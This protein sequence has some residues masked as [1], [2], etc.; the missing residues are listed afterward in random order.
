MSDSQ[1]PQVPANRVVVSTE[2]A[3]S[4]QSDERSTVSLTPTPRGD[5]VSVDIRTVR[6]EKTSVPDLLKQVS[7]NIGRRNS[8]QLEQLVRLLPVKNLDA[9]LS[10]PRPV[11]VPQQLDVRAFIQALVT[12]QNIAAK[13]FV[14]TSVQ[15][16]APTLPSTVLSGSSVLPVTSG[17]VNLEPLTLPPIQ[18]LL[19]APLQESTGQ[20]ISNVLPR[21]FEQTVVAPVVNS[22]AALTFDPTVENKIAFPQAPARPVQIDGRIIQLEPEVVKLKEPGDQGK[23][24][25][26][27][28]LQNIGTDKGQLLSVVQTP[29]A[30]SFRAEVIG[31]TPQNFPVVSFVP[32]SVVSDAGVPVQT[33]NFI[34]QAPTDNLTVGS[35]IHFMPISNNAGVAA[36][37]VETAMQNVI[38]TPF[39]S[40][41]AWP[42]F[43][44]F[45]TV[46]NQTSGKAQA[47]VLTQSMPNPAQPSR[48][49]AAMMFFIAAVRGGDLSAWSGDKAIEIVK[50]VGKSDVVDRL[51]R[52]VGNMQRTSTE[53]IGGQDWRAVA[54]PMTWDNEIHKMMLFFRHDGDDESGDAEQGK[55]TRFIF[56][57]N[58]QRMGA[59][60]LDG[61]TR[62]K[63]LD[64]II[65]SEHQFT[66]LMRTAMRGVYVNAL[67][68]SDLQGELGFQNSFE[69][70][71]KIDME[72]DSSVG[73]SAVN[74][75]L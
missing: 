19:Q 22:N 1:L 27:F 74:S 28:V 35:K 17:F 24:A 41:F 51:S 58:L 6:A 46:L 3:V 50:R 20:N 7:E 11:S 12:P 38:A 66:D 33:Q 39:Y 47:Q 13:P 75:M 54:M 36:P 60:Q 71:V 4:V 25:P 9:L 31:F 65:R 43:D 32:S 8:L 16:V 73:N 45:M 48:M 59:V 61:Y 52:D 29:Q 62:G 69:K 18:S 37:T 34:L 63:K 21:V 55:G 2:R 30:G 72:P 26:P 68:Q 14:S 44:E 53:P 10:V 56:D 70:F 64:L 23:A 67:E 49:P 40:N 15:Q 5:S 57:L 42:A